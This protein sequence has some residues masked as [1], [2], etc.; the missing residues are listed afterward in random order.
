VVLPTKTTAK[1]VLQRTLGFRRYLVA[2]SVFVAATISLRRS[3][4]QIRRFIDRLHA[5]A[6]VLDIGS[7]VGSMTLLFARRCPQ[8]HVYAFEP[9]KENIA[10]TWTIITLF[11]LPNVTMFPFGLGER[12][13]TV[14]M[15]M[16][17]ANGVRLE[18]LSHVLA[19]TEAIDE[20]ILY[21][22][23]L[24]RLDGLA[25]FD[26]VRV[27]AMKLD[28]EDYERFVLAGA[29]RI[30]VRDHPLIYAELWGAENRRG[31]FALL[32][33]HGYRV[34]YDDGQNVLFE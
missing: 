3:E 5:G 6:N 18:G 32:E 34:A 30:I 24:R 29:E 15:V 28:V 21:E 22:I 23:E 7:N 12:D 1:R 11:D 26:N 27:D 25:V 10:A 2:H 16:P 13:E 9:I 4:G 8:G 20:G 14:T 33:R 19:G 31:C 17:A